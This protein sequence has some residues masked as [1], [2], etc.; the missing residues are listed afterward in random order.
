M[1]NWNLDSIEHIEE[2]KM[3][4][5]KLRASVRFEEKE[6]RVL[7]LALLAEALAKDG[8][9]SHSFS[10]PL[11]RLFSEPISE[12]IRFDLTG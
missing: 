8:S 12:G 5:K 3:G 7:A 2:F 1:A 4:R 11:T 10:V 9:H 6:T